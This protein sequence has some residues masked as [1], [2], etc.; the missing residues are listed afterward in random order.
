MLKLEVKYFRRN[1]QKKIIR[2][3]SSHF[4]FIYTKI[5]L[6]YSRSWNPDGNLER[7]KNVLKVDHCISKKL[8]QHQWTLFTDMLPHPDSHV[9]ITAVPQMPS[10]N[11]KGQKGTKGGSAVGGQNYTAVT[12]LKQ[13]CSVLQPHLMAGS[14]F[15]LLY[16]ISR[17]RWF[18]KANSLTYAKS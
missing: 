5:R 11:Y 18:Y 10:H 14:L 1:N 17:Q 2:F 9:L 12:T 13:N 7:E 15:C 6:K 4:I 8:C 16:F 3:F